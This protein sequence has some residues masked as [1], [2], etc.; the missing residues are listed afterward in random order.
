MKW[1]YN[2]LTRILSVSTV[3]GVNPFVG[4]SL[5]LCT[6][7]VLSLSL[8]CPRN[9]YVFY[10]FHLDSKGDLRSSNILGFE[11]W[12]SDLTSMFTFSIFGLDFNFTMPW[13]RSMVKQRVRCI[14]GQYTSP[15][16][17][18]NYL[19]KEQLTPSS[20]LDI[21][22]EVQPHMDLNPGWYVIEMR[23]TTKKVHKWWFGDDRLVD[24]YYG[25]YNS[26]NG[27]VWPICKVDSR[28]GRNIQNVR[29]SV[30]YTRLLQ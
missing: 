2:L 21:V 20:I 18:Y 14:D 8:T 13:F 11:A 6:N 7:C 19:R 16:A 15:T 3:P 17:L 22:S 30:G 24:D 25:V 27:C 10:L 26:N 28:L 4:I 12:R 5:N 1:L 23:L 9:S 29:I